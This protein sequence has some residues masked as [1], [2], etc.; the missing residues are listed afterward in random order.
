MSFRRRAALSIVVLRGD[1]VAG[2]PA[3]YAAYVSVP[4]PMDLPPRLTAVL[5]GYG[6]GAQR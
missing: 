2:C 4:V 3:D 1:P 6:D 5:G